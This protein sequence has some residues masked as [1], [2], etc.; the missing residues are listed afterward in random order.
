[1]LTDYKY[2]QLII[3]DAH[4]HI[5][6]CFDLDLLLNSA[7]NNFQKVANSQNCQDNFVGVLFLTEIGARNQFNRLR[8]SNLANQHQ[9]TNW[10]FQATQEDVSLLA[11]NQSNQKIF[12][13]AGR[14][15]VTAENLEV[16]ALITKQ[17]FEDSLPIKTTIQAI[18]K[19]GGIPVIPWGV[20]KW[21]GKRGKILHSLLTENNSPLLCLG[22]NSGRPIFWSRPS[23][24]RQAETK[25]LPI[26]PGTDPLPLTSESSRPGSFGFTIQ[27]SLNLE[28]PGEHLKQILLESREFIVPYGSLENPWRFIRNQLAIRFTQGKT[29]NQLKAS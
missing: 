4:V 8:I 20:G 28:K 16:L 3:A 9:V 24:F 7:F 12:L 5:H 18:A 14:Q 29:I 2:K 15:I 26:L 11:C 19:A 1:M 13:I 27:N 6:D 10:S 23:Y 25:G 21:M 22:D 17:N